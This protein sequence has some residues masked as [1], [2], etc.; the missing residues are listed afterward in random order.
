MHIAKFLH[1]KIHIDINC[2]I[3]LLCIQIYCIY[4]SEA[5]ESFCNTV[6]NPQVTH[7]DHM[8]GSKAPRVSLTMSA[9]LK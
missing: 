2:N 1:Y 5:A 4:V 8:K 6:E 9:E 7:V 3:V